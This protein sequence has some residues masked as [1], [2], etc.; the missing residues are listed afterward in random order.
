MPDEEFRHLLETMPISRIR[1]QAMITWFYTLVDSN[2]NIE[3]RPEDRNLFREIEKSLERRLIPGILDYLEKLN[4]E[5]IPYA[6]VTNAK[7]EWI[8]VVLKGSDL[9][10]FFNMDNIFCRKWDDE[11]KKPEPYNYLRAKHKYKPSICV[12]YE[13]T[14]VGIIAARSVKV[15]TIIGLATSDNHNPDLLLQ[16]GADYIF[17]DY[18]HMPVHFNKND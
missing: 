3:V 9:R 6:M 2:S 12:S 5:S 14:P 10:L 4:T 1:T 7:M 17:K 11:P 13:D 18:V 15:H 16:S 8:E